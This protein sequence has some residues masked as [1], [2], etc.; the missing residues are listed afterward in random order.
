M[1]QSNHMLH[2]AQKKSTDA[3]EAEC[4]QGRVVLPLMC[5]ETSP[6]DLVELMLQSLWTFPRKGRMDA[7]PEMNGR[8]CC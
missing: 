7:G 2:N 4:S 8:Q 1:L 6:A 5:R 3:V